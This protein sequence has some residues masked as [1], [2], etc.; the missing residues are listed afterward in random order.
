MPQFLLK[1]LHWGLYAWVALL[2]VQISTKQL[3][4]FRLALSDLIL[5]LTVTLM[6]WSWLRTREP[7]VTSK[8]SIR[9][10]TS[11]DKYLLGLVLI[12]AVANVVAWLR[13]GHLSRYVLLN[14]DF[15]LL[16]L[17]LSFYTVVLLLR[18][19][20]RLWRLIQVILGS[21]LIVNLF[22]LV[23]YGAWLVWRIETPFVSHGRL[24]G[25]L[26]DPSAY[27]GYLVVVLLLQLGLLLFHPQ[28]NLRVQLIGGFNSF[29]LLAGIFFTLSR[30]TWLALGGGLMVIGW[31]ARRQLNWKGLLSMI[32]LGGLTVA[33]LGWMTK[34]DWSLFGY[35]LNE[36]SILDRWQ[37]IQQGLEHFVSSPLWGIG[38]GNF[39]ELGGSEII[40]NTYIWL[41]VEMGILGLAIFVGLLYRT[42][43][44]FLIGLRSPSVSHGWVV[45]AFA[46]WIAMLVFAL[47]IE[48]FYQ[49]HLWL[50]LAL[51]EIFRRQVSATPLNTTSP[52]STSSKSRM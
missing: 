40:H 15:G 26:I 27:G 29:L 30:S 46:A 13:V 38:L 43:Q 47:G 51:G 21:A 14:K 52:L 49:R 35:T 2:P 17:I 48:A 3:F 16:V 41:L 34:L 11:L 31:Q 25:L 5:A 23:T 45:G 6:L 24:V 42:G 33:L 19:P 37:L 44:N 22:S 1:R 7:F 36:N 39:R 4:G 50:L 8:P 18:N 32:F 12:F 9:W 28:T 20:E 10:R